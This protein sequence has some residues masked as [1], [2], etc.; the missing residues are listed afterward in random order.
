MSNII[1]LYVG[2]SHKLRFLRF[3]TFYI[4]SDTFELWLGGV[5]SSI[6]ELNLS[7]THFEIEISSIKLEIFQK[8]VFVL[9]GEINF[10]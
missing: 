9:L 1:I 5:P 6:F 8:V 7:D 10:M 3:D 2:F 4:L